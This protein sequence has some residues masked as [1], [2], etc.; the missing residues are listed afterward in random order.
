M[1]PFLDDERAESPTWLYRYYGPDFGL[2][3]IGISNQPQDRNQTH[4]GK[5]W[6]RCSSFMMLECFPLQHIAA[7]AE[8]YAIAL[9]DPAE[10]LKS[11]PPAKIGPMN[12]P[13]FYSESG[14]RLIGAGRYF[15]DPHQFALAPIDRPDG[16][17]SPADI[18][19]VFRSN[20]Y[21]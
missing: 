2:I 21:A 6:H 18:I 13:W 15:A 14:G 5:L 10:N 4:K 7:T 1:N 12:A 8:D 3:Y 9:E 17:I 16:F 20:R 19:P 11:R